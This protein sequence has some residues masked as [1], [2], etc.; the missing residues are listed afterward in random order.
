VNSGKAEL[1]QTLDL[2]L[3]TQV[4]YCCASTAGYDKHALKEDQMLIT[5][6]VHVFQMQRQQYSGKPL[7]SPTQGQ[8]FESIKC[9]EFNLTSAWSGTY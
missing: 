5:F 1:T 4:V 8:G 2:G 7:A 9:M 3:V 6:T